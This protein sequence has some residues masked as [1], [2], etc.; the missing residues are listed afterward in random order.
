MKSNNNLPGRDFPGLVV[1]ATMLALVTLLSACASDPPAT[2]V[3]AVSATT[4]AAPLLN[5]DSGQVSA[6]AY[7]QSLQRMS[8]TQLNRERAILAAVPPAP[9]IQLR[10][11][12]L[13]GYSRGQPDLPKAL[14]LLDAVLKSSDPV[15]IGLQPLARLLADNFGERQKLEAQLDKQGQQLKE[16]QRK[17]IELQEKIDGLADIERTLPQR[18][19]ATRPG[20]TTR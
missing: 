2:A 3:P 6:L 4:N 10:L 14:S 15:A 18:P 17:A 7:Y 13:L 19:R 8:P 16:S 12:M 20:S 1:T 9:G 11:A 5:D